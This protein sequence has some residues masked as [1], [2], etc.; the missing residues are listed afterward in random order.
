MSNPFRILLLGDGDSFHIERCLAELRRQGQTVKL[1]SLEQSGIVDIVLE[2]KGP[3]KSLHYSLAVAQLKTVIKA[4]R[5]DVL[6]AHYATGYGHLAAK[7]LQGMDTPYLLCLWGSDILRVPHK[8]R[9]HRAKANLALGNAAH[10]IADSEYLLAEARK[11][12][13]FSNSSVIPWGVER[14]FLDFYSEQ[15]KISRPPKVIV[16]RAHEEVYDNLFIVEALADLVSSGSIELTFPSFGSLYE[17]FKREANAISDGKVHYYDKMSRPEFLRF[18]STRD[19]CLSNASSDSSPVSLIEAM[20]LGLMAVA[21]DIPGVA[22]WLTS[23]TGYLYKSG[24]VDTLHQ[25]IE[26]I[27]S[28]KEDDNVRRQSNRNRV[29]SE[30]LFEEN[31]AQQ[32]GIMRG[33]A[34][35][36]GK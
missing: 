2:R 19:I 32:I 7:A 30:A 8:S 29:L 3:I 15:K 17:S 5:P 26:S 36:G 28:T 35:E 21:R 12:L 20:G 34:A 16:P 9:L 27:C 31:I 6:F 22:E 11:I 13:K 14:E 18:F 25:I 33:L 24:D 1:C 10:I 23:E 4:F